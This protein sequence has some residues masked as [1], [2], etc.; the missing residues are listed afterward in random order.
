M[1]DEVTPVDLDLRLVRYF[2]CL[3]EHG[4]FGRAAAELYLGQPALSRS[5]RRLE[6]QLGVALFRRT[7]RG[8]RL[9]AAGE[10]FRPF[11]RDLHR[12][13]SR[14]VAAA[15]AA[16]RPRRIRVGYTTNL[17]VTAALVPLRRRH[18]DAEVQTRHLGWDEP[19]RALH[20]EL[21]DVVVARLPLPTAGLS[22][23][24]L[25]R[26]GR[27]LMVS[28]RHRLA[29]RAST[30]F[31]EIADDPVPVFPD[32][33]WNAFWRVDPRPGGRPAPGGPLVER[34]A[35][36]NEWVASGTCIS[37]IPAGAVPHQVHPG[38]T[39]VA[40]DGVPPCEVVALWRSDD[41]SELV[42]D[43]VT[44]AR[45][46]LTGTGSAAAREAHPHSDPGP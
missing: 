11:A 3:A 41:D 23:A 39:T 40:I 12:E 15:R 2:L 20:E 21:V 13:A 30:T 44:A 17:V 37:F 43:F 18:P 1:A 32:P 45:A 6:E 42:G 22:V 38:C 31:A 7:S 26:E 27:V 14:G 4:H 35:D 8:A 16:A 19:V 28:T 25:H 10:A 36:S 24:P 9:T 46:T 33:L 34:T 5:I 29:G